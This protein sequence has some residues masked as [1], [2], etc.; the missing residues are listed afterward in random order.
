VDL[1]T[2]S[3]VETGL[4][5]SFDIAVAGL[6]STTVEPASEIRVTTG[7]PPQ[8]CWDLSS[9]PAAACPLGP[10]LAS[11]TASPP[12]ETDVIAKG[13]LT[14]NS[15]TR[16]FTDQTVHTTV[17]TANFETCGARLR[18]TVV[19][20]SDGSPVAGAKVFLLD[21]EGKPVLDSSGQPVSAVSAADGTLEFPVWVADYTLKMSGTDSYIP[22]YMEVTAGGSGTT[23]PVNG[24][25]T[26]NTVT[27]TA[28]Q[29]SHVQIAVTTNQPTSPPPPGEKDEAWFQGSGCTA[30]GGAQSAL[31]VMLVLGGLAVLR[32]R[33]T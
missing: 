20:L 30:A 22:A 8:L 23:A 28:N 31:V 1:S 25:V 16:P 6:G 19:S 13:S 33:R 15:T 4:T 10:A 32:R 24:T 29:T 26:S 7:S 14:A 5:P 18:A 12:R 9:P 3:T 21:S 17:A 11:T 2:L 27:T